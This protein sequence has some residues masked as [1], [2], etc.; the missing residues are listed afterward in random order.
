[1]LAGL[2][3]ALS[4]RLYQLVILLDAF[5]LFVIQ[6]IVAG[7]LLPFLGN[8]CRDLGLSGLRRT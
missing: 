2:S 1:M 5:L 4:R 3:M 8:L 6:P 7:S